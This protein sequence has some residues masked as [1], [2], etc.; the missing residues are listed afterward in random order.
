LHFATAKDNPP[1]KNGGLSLSFSTIETKSHKYRDLISFIGKI[2]RSDSTVLITGESGTGK[3]FLAKELHHQSKRKDKKFS[4]LNCAALSDQLLES[5]LFGHARGSFTGAT[6]E[7]VGRLQV[8]DGGTIFL[9]EIAETSLRFQ[10]ALLRFI[11]D[12]EFERVGGLTTLKVD[13]RL[14]AATNRDLAS[15]VK[16]GAFR[17]DLY[18]RLKVFSLEMPPLRERK[19]DLFD[20]IDRFFLE[21][22]KVIPEWKSEKEFTDRI[23]S[24]D[25][26]GNIRELRNTI[27]R[28][29]VL[30]LDGDAL[31]ELLPAEINQSTLKIQKKQNQIPD[32]NHGSVSLEEMERFYIE[33]VISRTKTL[34]DAATILGINLSTL[35][36]KRKEYRE[37]YNTYPTGYKS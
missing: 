19:E 15:A 31:S 37:K 6:N 23:L 4:I 25:W 29:S 24:Y 32:P 27:E 34:H 21:F 5:E 35:W 26:P 11:Q 10:T 33:S 7:K 36:R 13:V 30:H 9:D 12:R 20:L 18:W 3:S 14:I 16:A 8:A 1:T 28:I 2:A 17:E 22:K